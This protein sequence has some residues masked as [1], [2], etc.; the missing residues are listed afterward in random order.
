VVFSV[1]IRWNGVDPKRWLPLVR[2]QWSIY[3][4]APWLTATMNFGDVRA[5]Y[6][7]NLSIKKAVLFELEAEVSERS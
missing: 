7:G 4:E 1:R 6:R 5:T 2:R 3:N